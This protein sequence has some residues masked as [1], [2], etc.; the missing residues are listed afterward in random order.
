MVTGVLSHNGKVFIQKR[1]A[2]DVWPN[3][4]EFPGGVLHNGETPENALAREYLEETEIPI[5]VDDKITTLKHSYTKYRVTM[6]CYFCKL[7]QGKMKPQLHAA[8]EYKWVSSEELAHYAFPAPHR[9]LIKK[10]FPYYG[11]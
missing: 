6:H 8:Q 5:K 1:Q 3:L 2:D 4:W 7:A 11:N 9:R 10:I